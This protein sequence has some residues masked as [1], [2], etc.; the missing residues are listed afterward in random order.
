MKTRREKMKQGIELMN[1]FWYRGDK[2]SITGMYRVSDE[3]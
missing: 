3:I 2:P 1:T